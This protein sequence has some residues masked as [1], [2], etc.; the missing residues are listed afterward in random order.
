MR[1]TNRLYPVVSFSLRFITVHVLTYLGFGIFFMI[2]SK[3]FAY[4]SHDPMFSEVMK[5]SDALS[6]R[7][8]PV[9][10][11]VRGGFLA[12]AVYP[13]RVVIIER[14]SGWI[15]LFVL[16]FVFSSIGSVITGPGS[17]E[18]LLYTRFPFDPVIGY[19]EIA[20]QMFVFSYWFC[21]WQGKKIVEN[22][23]YKAR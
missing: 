10:Q 5:P 2:V 3:Y 17:I 19:P 6:V 13:F 9:V 18:G 1:K 23:H 20:L 22:A 7:I 15:K 12:L 8:A 14:T 16:L 11:V 21:R 4:F